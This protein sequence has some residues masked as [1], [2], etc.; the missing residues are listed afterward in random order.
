MRNT[1]AQSVY[2]IAREIP[3]VFVVVSDISPVG[4]IEGFR[5]EFPE[6]FI[7][8]GVAEQSMIGICSGLA[9][10]GCTPFAYTIATFTAYRPFEHI[11]SEVCYQ[12]LPVTIVGMGAGVTYG[13]LGGTHHAQEDIGILGSLPNM[14]IL[15]PCDPAETV[16]AT[17]ASARH[18]GPVYLRIGKAGE[19]DLTSHAPEPFEFGK[20]RLLRQGGDTCI[21][22]YGPIM[23]M[24]F[25]IA[26]KLEKDGG[27]S[28]S[29]V[30]A[31]TLKPLD[32]S[33]IAE[34]LNGYE[35]VVVIEEHSRMNGL[36]AHVRQIAWDCG[37]RCQL[38]TFGL[39]DEFI[40][41]FGSQPDL[42]RAH[43][44]STEIICRKMSGVLGVV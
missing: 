30:S 39:Q 22:S 43:G 32:T 10:R 20:L 11:R 36:G 44:L 42:W 28:V 35:T 40:H 15:A 1:F 23:G 34:I 18:S 17:W 14:S 25:E 12:N 13:T 5:E 21:I 26:K 41:A 16:A 8:V 31:H 24:A 3:D 37:A 27:R 19:P 9:L 6:Q 29:I 7:N 4:S 2:D 33:G 38:H